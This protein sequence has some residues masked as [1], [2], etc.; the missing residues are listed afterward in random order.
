MDDLCALARDDDDEN[1]I[2]NHLKTS[3]KSI[4]RMRLDISP[5]FA[6]RNCLFTIEDSG[7]VGEQSR[8]D[9]ESLF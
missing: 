1:S 7:I 4:R 3:M 9:R 5:V 6:R 8:V 2:G